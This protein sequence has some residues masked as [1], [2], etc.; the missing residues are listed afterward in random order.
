MKAQTAGETLDLVEHPAEVNTLTFTQIGN[1]LRD[2]EG[3]RP[4]TFLKI[5]LRVVC[6]LSW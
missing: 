1:S 2:Q 6:L 5:C 4:D 3:F